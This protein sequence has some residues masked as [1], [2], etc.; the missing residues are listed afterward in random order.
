MFNFNNGDGLKQIAYMRIVSVTTVGLHIIKSKDILMRKGIN[1][2][3][4]QIRMLGS[5][6]E[7]I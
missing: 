1:L 4:S 7:K 3:V 5:T 6:D 2:T